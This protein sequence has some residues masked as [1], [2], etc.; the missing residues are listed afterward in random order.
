MNP[1]LDDAQVGL[2]AVS[3]QAEATSS[4]TRPSLGSSAF[5]HLLDVGKGTWVVGLS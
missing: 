1:D 5:E 4:S 2:V 3:S